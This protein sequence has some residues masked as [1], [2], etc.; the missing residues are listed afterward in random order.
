MSDIRIVALTTTGMRGASTYSSKLYRL[1]PATIIPLDQPLYALVKDLL[2][3]DIEICHIQYEYSSLGSPLITSILLTLIMILL[4][5]RGK[6]IV[7][8]VHGVATKQSVSSMMW[9]WYRKI[10]YIISI[11]YKLTY[12]VI[13]SLVH[14]IIV[15]TD[16]MRD[17]LIDYGTNREKVMVIPHGSDTHQ[18][19]RT[20]N[21]ETVLFWGFIR[22]HKGIEDLISA[23]K[24]LKVKKKQVSLIIAGYSKDRR[25]ISQ[26]KEL[27]DKHNLNVS[28][29]EGFL[30]DD[31]VEELV[32]EARI[33]VLPYKD[34]FLEVSGILHSLA[35]FGRPVICSKIPRFTAEL[36]D[37][38]DCL[39]FEAGDVKSLSENIVK[40]LRDD[41]LSYKLGSNLRQKFLSMSWDRI[42]DMHMKL[43][44]GK[45]DED[46]F[47]L[48]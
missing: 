35:T 44:E 13:S 18:Q 45:R 37:G 29:V 25:Y 23:V 34:R 36:E 22:P 30:T 31:K 17:A 48:P 1:L 14:K 46:R 43:Y 26:L 40:L 24:I 7:I 28:F 6:R 15:H 21:C 5:L 19:L 38:V 47:L 9:S 11:S 8:T 2:K 32:K 27:V 41:D 39:M 4:N 16:L 10:P 12:R 20:P 3:L 42:A 33:I